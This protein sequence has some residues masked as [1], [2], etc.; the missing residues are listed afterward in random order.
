MRLYT[1]GH[2]LG[3]ALASLAAYELS[4]IVKEVTWHRVQ[5]LLLLRTPRPNPCHGYGAPD[6][7]RVLVCTPAHSACLGSKP[8]PRPHAT[9]R[10]GSR[11]HLRQ[12]RDAA[13][14]R[15]HPPPRPCHAPHTT[16]EANRVHGRRGCHRSGC[17]WR[18]RQRRRRHE[19]RGGP[20]F[21]RPAP[22]RRCEAVE[23]SCVV[24]A[25]GLPPWVAR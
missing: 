5:R 18:R 1:T 23:A 3:G 11:Q 24:D 6:E 2:S 7:S 22:G 15:P 10:G 13:G 8:L 19:G 4:P 17:A 9:V 12:R 21:R 25:A 14:P 20:A 16:P